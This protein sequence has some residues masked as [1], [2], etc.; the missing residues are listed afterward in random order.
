MSAA[1]HDDLKSLLKTNEVPDNVIL[2]TEKLGCHAVKMFANW[3]DQKSELQAAI[4]DHC[5]TDKQNRVA[6]AGL[7]QAWRESLNED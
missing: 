4:L 3:V 5:G 1:M 7:K 6:L 2:G